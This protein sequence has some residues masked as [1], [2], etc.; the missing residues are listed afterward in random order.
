MQ[1][2]KHAAT[3]MMWGAPVWV[4]L[5]T[6][7]GLPIANEIVQRSKVKSNSLLQVVGNVADKLGATPLCKIPI[8]AQILATLAVM[9]TPT[10]PAIQQPDNASQR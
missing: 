2:L 3:Y 6:V 4:W 8:V 1:W 7:V 9:K 5:L 10:K